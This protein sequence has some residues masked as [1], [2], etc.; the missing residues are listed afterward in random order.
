MYGCVSWI[1][2]Y[3]LE[4]MSVHFFLVVFWDWEW[5]RDSVYLHTKFNRADWSH[6]QFI[7][8]EVTLL[9]RLRF[10]MVSRLR[11][12]ID[13]NVCIY[14]LLIYDLFM[15][16]FGSLFSEIKWLCHDSLNFFSFCFCFHLE[17]TLS[18]HV[19]H[20]YFIGKRLHSR[21][22]L[23]YYLVFKEKQMHF[24]NSFYCVLIIV[25]EMA[26]SRSPLIKIL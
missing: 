21:R 17:V 8:V 6:L 18:T 22:P 25:R 12:S 13:I 23:L 19:F 7:P 9:L 14:I 2:T 20:L 1:C 24:E 3:A 5:L 10:W 4:N 26:M 11:F 16:H 15:Y